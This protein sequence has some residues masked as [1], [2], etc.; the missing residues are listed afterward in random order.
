MPM[1]VLLIQNKNKFQQQTKNLAKF[2]AN[3]QCSELLT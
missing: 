1:D 3:Q 2:C